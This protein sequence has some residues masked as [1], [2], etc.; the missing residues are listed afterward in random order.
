MDFSEFLSLILS[1]GRM[2]AGS[3]NSYQQLEQALGMQAAL[4]QQSPERE[5]QT[6]NIAKIAE[7]VAQRACKVEGFVQQAINSTMGP[8]PDTTAKQG[9]KVAGH[10]GGD[11]GRIEA[12]L[13]VITKCLEN[14]EAAVVRL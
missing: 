9:E 1:G 2:D 5:T 8:G 11:M 10:Y 3:M 13:V 7:E 4:S 12:C 14:I 6:G